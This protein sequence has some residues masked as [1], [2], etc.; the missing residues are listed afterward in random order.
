MRRREFLMTATGLL[1]QQGLSGCQVGENAALTVQALKGSIPAQLPDRFRR[2]A[3]QLFSQRPN[4]Q[5]TAV[6]QL[7]GLFKQL[8]QWQQ[9]VQTQAEPA[10]SPWLRFG[11]RPGA[12]GAADLVSLGDYWL[13]PAIRQ[14][15]IQPLRPQPW[16]HW[17]QVPERWQALV[18]R[19]RQGMLQPNGEVW[20]APYR[21]GT[22]LIAYREDAFQRLGWQPTDWPDLWRS[23]LR[24]RLSLLDQP[25]EVIGLALK[26]LGYSYNETDLEAIS[27]LR[28]T[29]HAL[30]QQVKFYSSDTYLQPLLLGD[31]WLAVGWS[32]EVLPLLA[33]NR[34]I[35]VVIPRSGTAIWNDVWVRPAQAPAL[36]A[37]HPPTFA[38]AWIDFCWDP[39]VALQLSLI[40]RAAS[41]IVTPQSGHRDSPPETR[42][43]S[44][45]PPS[46]A[47][48]QPQAIQDKDLAKLSLQLPEPDLLDRCE[49]LHP[50]EASALQQYRQH[51]LTM[52]QA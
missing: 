22:T 24:H 29:L 33:Y 19:D 31:T 46:P 14:G 25:R 16:T 34:G 44:D 20:A 6:P 28:S 21:W 52:R 26:S 8:Q 38:D 43:E 27:D 18:R 39:D 32:N 12:K 42:R 48:R 7:D 30:H 45:A 15:L 23:E 4:L 37:N 11:S 9:Q 2:H 13:T 36:P 40:T 17:A 5:L 51:W 41:P 35:R 47:T 50:L 3:A 1:L 10:S 49:F